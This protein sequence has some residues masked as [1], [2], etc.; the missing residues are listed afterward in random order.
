MGNE[1]M[2]T[3]RYCMVL[4]EAQAPEQHRLQVGWPYVLIYSAQSW[5]TPFV[6]IN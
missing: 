3:L 2:G 6:P 1:K 4:L 5:F